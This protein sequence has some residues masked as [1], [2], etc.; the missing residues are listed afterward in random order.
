MKRSKWTER[1]FTFDFPEGW[2]CNIVERLLGAPPRIKH[3]V[4]GISD[5][6]AA[7][8]PRNEWSIKQHIGHLTDLEE[9]HSKRI[10]ELSK[11]LTT[12]SAADMS[13]K[14]TWEAP[15]NDRSLQ[16]LIRDFEIARNHFVKSLLLLD[17]KK[18]IHTALHPRLQTP[19]RAVDVAYFTAEHDDHHLAT[20]RELVK[21]ATG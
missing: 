13:N 14:K 3:M 7:G 6:Q 1:H 19:M 11:G 4:S 21:L 8:S 12:L 5:V 16:S 9:L 18:H 20:I 15:H 10:G 17:E 2:L